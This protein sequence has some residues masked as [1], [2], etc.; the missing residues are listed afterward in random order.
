MQTQAVHTMPYF[1]AAIGKIVGKV[2]GKRKDEKQSSAKLD[3]PKSPSEG[4]FRE[5][6]EPRSPDAVDSRRAPPRRQRSSSK[7]RNEPRPGPSKVPSDDEREKSPD[8]FLGVGRRSRSRK[9]T[10]RSASKERRKE[11]KNATE[12]PITDDKQ[13]EK[14]ATSR[15]SADR[16]G[17][18]KAPAKDKDHRGSVKVNFVDDDD[19]DNDDDFQEDVRSPPKRSKFVAKVQPTVSLTR[20]GVGK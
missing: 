11:S 3:P 10:R 9:S 2:A 16:E 18:S 4:I 17:G 20:L 8:I 6:S 15:I 12:K 14:V 19:D 5:E 13:Q 7:E 1:G